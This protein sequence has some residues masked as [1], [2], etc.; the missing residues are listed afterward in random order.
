MRLDVEQPELEYR[1]QADGPRADD[2]NIGLDR[3][4]HS[5]RPGVGRLLT[6]GFR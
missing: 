4:A 1:K 5:F 2:E 6:S 3:F